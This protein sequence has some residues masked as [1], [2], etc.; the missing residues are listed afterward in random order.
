MIFKSF[1]STIQKYK[2]LSDT[3]TIIIGLSG[4]A[5]SVTLAHLF[6]AIS[7]R[8]GVKLI[9]VHVNHCIRGIEA[10][11]DENFVKKFCDSLSIELQIQKVD[12][13]A[14]SKKLKIGIEEA[15]RKARY[16]V[17]QKI[18]SKIPNS[19]IATAHTLSDNAETII[20]RLV[21]GTGLKGL[22][23]IPPVRDN[24]IRPLIEIQ[25]QQIEK[26]CYENNL[27]YM[28]DSSNLEKNYTRNK[29]RLEILP[30]IKNINPN[31]EKAVARTTKTITDDEMYLN[32]QTEIALNSIKTQN[33]WDVS[34]LINFDES[35]KNRVIFKILKSLTN[36]RI[37]QKHVDQIKKIIESQKGCAYIPGR[38]MVSVS[39]GLL[40]LESNK[41]LEK[42]QWQYPIK[43]LNILTEIKTTI[44]IKVVSSIEY[45]NMTQ[46][47]K[48]HFVGVLDF[49][50]LS[51]ES[52]FRNRRPGDTFRFP[53]RKISKSVKKIFN[54]M[55]IPLEQRY[56]IPILAYGKEILWIDRIGV[57]EAYLPSSNTNKVA[58]IIKE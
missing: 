28:T 14:L 57:S 35:L 43:P 32:K 51:S 33:S 46:S 25:R 4:G 24:I 31:F 44:I 54:E 15:G 19:K 27:Q 2:M 52:V 37:E 22:C 13:V 21:N 6:S 10:Q 7:K 38:G 16:E 41:S 49:D 20:M 53:S 23:G 42:S 5:D 36:S 9:A 8:Y 11:R 56:K 39:G 12:V 45:E 55:K 34:K 26:Y 30:L 18:S 29:I 17:F 48:L 1:L 3:K 40:V 58:I 47:D 50:K